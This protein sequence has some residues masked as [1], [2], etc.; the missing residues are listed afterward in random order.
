MLKKLFSDKTPLDK[1]RYEIEKTYNKEIQSHY[2]AIEK[3]N[4][5][6]DQLTQKSLK[7]YE[8]IERKLNQQVSAL[9]TSLDKDLG[10][11]EKNHQQDLKIKEESLTKLERTLNDQ[12]KAL[13]LDF[14][15]TMVYL[16]DDLKAIDEEKAIT[17][18]EIEKKYL[19]N[20]SI[21]E[22]KLSLFKKNL[23]KNQKETKQKF[24]TIIKSLNDLLENLNTDGFKSY[25]TF[26]EQVND[27]Y[28]NYID[29]LSLE[30]TSIE[31]IRK[32]FLNET[33]NLRKS[34]NLMI[35]D[36]DITISKTRAL[37][38]A[39]FIAFSKSLS[40]FDQSI[41]GHT[42]KI[43]DTI[44]Q[45]Y[46]FEMMRLEANTQN[47]DETSNDKEKSKDIKARTKLA[48]AKKEALTFEFEQ[49]ETLFDEESDYL[50]TL[51][52]H[53]KA[54]LDQAI[55]HYEETIKMIHN[56]LKDLFSVSENYI[57]KFN[58]DLTAYTKKDTLNE[59]FEA[60]KTLF[61]SALESF[62]TY[63][64]SRINA[65]IEYTEKR[66]LTSIE[67]DEISMFLDT[68]EPLKEIETSKQ[69]IKV[70]QEDA[71]IKHDIDKANL[72]HQR[73]LKTLEHETHVKQERFL[74]DLKLKQAKKELDLLKVKQDHER[75]K[76]PLSIQQAT[77]DIIHESKQKH[78]ESD[79]TLLENKFTLEKEKIT[80]ETEIKTLAAKKEHELSLIE[81]EKEADEA[82]LHQTNEIEQLKQALNIKLDQLKA[83]SINEDKQIEKTLKLHEKEHH[84]AIKTLN[85]R[86]ETKH[87]NHEEALRF[88]D[89]ALDKEIAAP[90]A[91]QEEI[92]NLA[93]HK[94]R[95]LNEQF[96]FVKSE[97][98]K[99][100][101]ALKSPEVSFKHLLP[102]VGDA[103]I[104]DVKNYITHTFDLLKESHA[105]VY[106]VTLKQIDHL[107]N[108]R[109][110]QTSLDKANNDYEKIIQKI[111][112]SKDHL[113]EMIISRIQNAKSLIKDDNKPTLQSI[114]SI[115]KPLSELLDEQINKHRLALTEEITSLFKELTLSDAL[116]IKR[117]KEN[118]EKAIQQEKMNFQKLIAP[119][120]QE[121][122]E[123][124]DAYETSLETIKQ[125]HEAK[126]EKALEPINARIEAFRKEIIDKQTQK[127][128]FLKR[129][130][131]QR[132]EAIARYQEALNLIQ[133]EKE[134]MIASLKEKTQAKKQKLKSR[135][136]DAKALQNHEKH[137]QQ[138]STENL[139]M[140]LDDKITEIS[141]AY[142]TAQGSI[143][144]TIKQLKT[145]LNQ[146]K[147]QATQSLN[148]A[149]KH[150]EERMLSTA[151]R[152]EQFIEE[153]TR[154]L[155]QEAASK[156]Q[157]LVFLHDQETSYHETLNKTLNDALL[158]LKED[159]NK[160]L[161]HYKDYLA[162]LETSTD[163]IDPL[164]KTNDDFFDNFIENALDSLLDKDMKG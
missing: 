84:E 25:H 11:L 31:E 10:L 75:K 150:F 76:L 141:Y 156:K 57:E 90:K 155:N 117:A 54:L 104:H 47:Q 135:L 103:F 113:V 149:L 9:E 21:Y 18:K 102:L 140:I 20:T 67:I 74:N 61:T 154:K 126:K 108:P 15:K 130:K 144:E 28:K 161:I 36:I 163:N 91:H 46:T 160:A 13:K 83:Q 14:E 22:D 133:K 49:L 142:D 116:I 71:S 97:L 158:H 131:D 62:K 4:D 101:D 86:I 52:N 132:D 82:T 24:K 138:V 39:P 6:L 34:L 145:T 94:V 115:I 159:L 95:L 119:I 164:I 30:T 40:N 72:N 81:L 110:K 32:E 78:I 63:E 96:A 124:N 112:K 136:E 137:M 51:L 125:A 111:D 77:I 58:N 48:Q 123:K 89:K 70:E 37:I 88:I 85:K 122:K 153:A 162:T 107:D 45:D 128:L 8:N 33:L 139:D 64:E 157:K 16:E 56:K 5:N 68:L 106:H 73:T 151:P 148:Q 41:K 105:F 129:F 43:I 50:K 109:K 19:S 38:E 17:L 55:D 60:L 100:K 80:L 69:K 99:V 23:D 42:T 146:E 93:N 29:K 120:E 1:A 3:V 79:L 147:D 7:D 127:D 12:I 134:S 92:H 35:K 65:H 152:L 59:S 44:N 26:D 121:L 114:R 118:H 2:K 27:L 66:L 98:S 143:D 87:A 53:E